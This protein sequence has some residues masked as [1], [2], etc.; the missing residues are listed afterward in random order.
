MFGPL[1]FLEN[2]NFEA[3]KII[4]DL[5]LVDLFWPMKKDSH[6]PP[7]HEIIKLALIPSSNQYKHRR[8]ID[9]EDKAK[10]I[11]SDWGTESLQR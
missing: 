1:E 5:W 3:P 4:P 6:T 11:A 7:Y 10:V 8:R 9:L 2:E